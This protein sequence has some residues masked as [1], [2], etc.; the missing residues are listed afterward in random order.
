M[1]GLSQTGSQG[2]SELVREFN[3]HETDGVYVCVCV[4]VCDELTQPLDRHR[5]EDLA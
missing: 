1:Y 2:S 3:G 5:N 4:H